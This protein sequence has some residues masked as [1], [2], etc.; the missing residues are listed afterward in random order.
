[1]NHCA[2]EIEEAAQRGPGRHAA[3]GGGQ[4][5]EACC[6]NAAVLPLRTAVF[7][8]LVL[9]CPPS[10]MTLVAPGVRAALRGP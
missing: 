7:L 1:M 6:R 8:S 10:G 4:D 2:L 5:T 9:T 3:A